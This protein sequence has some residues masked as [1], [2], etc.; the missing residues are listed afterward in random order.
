MEEDC[1]LDDDFVAEGGSSD[2]V[3]SLVASA[4]RVIRFVRQAIE[5]MS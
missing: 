4:S 3:D 1:G 5:L 2:L